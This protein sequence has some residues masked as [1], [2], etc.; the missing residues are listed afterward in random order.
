MNESADLPVLE[1]V[2]GGLAE[3]P[4]GQGPRGET[5][6]PAIFV[7]A[8]GHPEILALPDRFHQ[9]GDP[10]WQCGSTWETEPIALVVEITSPTALAFKIALDRQRHAAIIDALLRE[11]GCYVAPTSPRYGIN[12]R[13]MRDHSFYC[14]IDRGFTDTWKEMRARR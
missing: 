4:S 6:A 8:N 1:L 12:A 11:G 13:M 7:D 10:L 3:W 5:V 9:V 2:G 14:S